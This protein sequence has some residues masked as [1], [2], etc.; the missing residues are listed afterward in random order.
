M[1]GTNRPSRKGMRKQVIWLDTSVMKD[2]QQ[3]CFDQDR[4]LSVVLSEITTTAIE[5]AVAAHDGQGGAA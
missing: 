3:M 5:Q 1:D 4:N 2:L